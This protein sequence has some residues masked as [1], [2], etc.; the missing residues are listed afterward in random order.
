MRWKVPPLCA[1]GSGVD[2]VSRARNLATRESG[3]ALV[4]CDICRAELMRSDGTEELSKNNWLRTC[5]TCDERCCRDCLPPDATSCT[6][7]QKRYAE[8][9]SA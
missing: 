4:S 9:P 2:R 3:Y 1:V 7:C 8:G 5:G 6:K